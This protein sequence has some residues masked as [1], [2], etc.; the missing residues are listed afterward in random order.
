MTRLRLGLQVVSFKAKSRERHQ[1]S[2]S[3]SGSS[4]TRVLAGDA[5]VSLGK[6][7]WDCDAK[8]LIPPELEVRP[9]SITRY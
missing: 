2:F 9:V 5:G 7:A 4:A 1:L 8:C 6:G 3:T